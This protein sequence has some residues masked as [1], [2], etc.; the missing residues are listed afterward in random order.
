MLYNKVGI[1]TLKGAKTNYFWGVIGVLIDDLA[2]IPI[3]GVLGSLIDY[4]K[5]DNFQLSVVFLRLGIMFLLVLASYLG[6][7]TFAYCCF[8]SSGKIKMYYKQR[9]FYKML[10]KSPDFFDKYTSGDIMALS[11]NDTRFIHEYFGFGIMQLIDFTIIPLVTIIYLSIFISFEL[12][13]MILLPYPLIILST[14]YF[15][16]KIHDVTT[17]SNEKFGNVNQE[18]LEN[19]E[20]IRLV[21]SYVNEQV[22]LNKLSKVVKIY[23]DLVYIQSKFYIYMYEFNELLKEISLAIGFIFG[24]YLIN[25]GRISVGQLVSF[26]AIC[27]SFAW[28]FTAAGMHF[29]FYKRADAAIDRINAFLEDTTEV[30]D[31]TL[32]CGEFKSL[33]FKDFSFKYPNSEN[34]TLKNL[35]FKL[36]RGETLGIVGR[37]GSGKTTLVKQILR[38]YNFDND[39]VFLN[40]IP[41]EKYKL[42]SVR[43]KFGYVSQENVLL[44]STVRENILFGDEFL[45]DEKIIEVMKKADFY[46]DIENLKDGLDTVVG[47]RG[48][49]LS[50]GQKQ[51]ISLARALYRDPE[52]LVLDDSFSAVDANTE[53]NIVNSLK[54]Y[55]KTKTNIIVS[56][57]IS[58]VEH[59]D[60]ILVLENGKIVECGKHSDLIAKGGWYKEQFEYQSL[61]DDKEEAYEE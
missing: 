21:R 45:N 37:S 31:G 35:N 16:K 10:K 22:R 36:N 60:L 18:I 20:G 2:V 4:L 27:G 44:S 49:G 41:F 25:V 40:D 14:N 53:F 51:R 43:K 8:G 23:F 24:M 7:I 38:L 34:Y 33:E 55:R 11:S 9:I 28:S 5:N 3:A 29:N 1:R 42:H 50:G 46:K 39:K 6:F 61:N 56:H 26:F 57:R 59:S 12:T 58:A 47:E 30:K 52:V 48:L 15:G 54:K 13:L 32:E 19:I 17:K